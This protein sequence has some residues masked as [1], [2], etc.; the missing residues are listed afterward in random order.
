M[1]A[2]D[3]AV[4][5]LVAALAAFG[6]AYFVAGP[7]R[8]RP[9]AAAP[10]GDIPLAQRPYHSDDE[11]E[12]SGLDRAMSWGVALTL[13]MAFFLPIYWILEPDRM[14]TYR[15]AYYELDVEE[16]RVEFQ[17]A[18]AQCHGSDAGGGFAPHPDPEVDAPWPVP[19]LNNI[20]ARYE[21]NPNVT[22]L[23]AFMIQTI[24]QGRP[25]TPMPAWGA[26]YGGS[27]NDQQVEAIVEY[28]LAIQPLPGDGASEEPPQ[29]VA[30]A[31]GREI[32]QTNCARCHGQDA[33]GGV[34]P[35]LRGEFARFGA[36]GSEANDAAAREAVR[37][38]IVNGRIVPTGASMPSFK[39][40]LPADAISLLIQYLESI[41]ETEPGVTAQAQ[42]SAP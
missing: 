9:R 30:G 40:V 20:A 41:Q 18:C 11:L 5:V 2:R 13:F 23:R 25:G 1:E 33:E 4:L 6:V 32:F 21:D 26:F 42:E 15:D 35:E 37:S 7:G 22:D 19:A 24:K 8:R 34:G 3:I 28:L 31:S 36:D 16:G 14:N 38:T 12:S 17:T 27:M 10:P 39:D 29:A